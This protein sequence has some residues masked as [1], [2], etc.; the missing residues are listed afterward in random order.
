MRTDWHSVGTVW[1]NASFMV[2]GINKSEQ[3]TPCDEMPKGS[4][5]KIYKICDLL[6]PLHSLAI[7]DMTLPA[8]AEK[9]HDVDS[10]ESSKSGP[11]VMFCPEFLPFIVGNSVA[12][13]PGPAAHHSLLSCVHSCSWECKNPCC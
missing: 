8:A 9:V 10:R 7:S 4:D 12:R 6:L 13:W 11:D 1:G 5:A 2:K 3:G